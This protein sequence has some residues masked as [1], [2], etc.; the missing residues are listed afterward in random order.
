MVYF[1]GRIFDDVVDRH[2][3]Y[4]GRRP[5]LLA[6]NG[7]KHP[8]SEGVEGLTVLTGLLLCAEL[9]AAPRPRRP[10]QPRILERVAGSFRRSVIGAIMENTEA[11]SWSADY[12]ERLIHLK[13]VDYWRCVYTALDPQRR[14]R[15]TPS[16]S[17]TT[18]SARS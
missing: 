15:S 12:Y 6:E 17:A 14:C 3:W 11:E 10:D 7:P 13:N 9:G 8:S 1:V 5:T 16:S 18:R 2:F 4:K